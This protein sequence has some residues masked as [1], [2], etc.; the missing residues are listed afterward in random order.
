MYSGLKARHVSVEGSAL[1]RYLEGGG[2]GLIRE[3][4][5]D[6]VAF[7]EGVMADEGSARWSKGSEE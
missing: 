7:E 1:G 3:G 5:L 2:H 4:F 6:K